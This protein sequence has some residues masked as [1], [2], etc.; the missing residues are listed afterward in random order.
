MKKTLLILVASLGFLALPVS[1]ETLT[2]AAASDLSY[3]IDELAAA[4]ALQVP[5]A[6]LKTS[7]GSSG[8]IYAQIRNGAPFDVFM[9]ADMKYP[10]QLAQDGAAERATLAPYAVG[11]I[12]LWSLDPRFDLSQGMRILNDARLNRIA[13]ANPDVAP[14]GR[15]ARA[16][17]MA[18]GFWGVV[19]DKLVLG[20][21]I[22]QTAQLVQSG[23][24]QIGIVSYPTVLAPKVRGSGSYYLIPED[25]VPPIEQGVIVTRHG[26]ANPLAPRFL[27][28]L[29]STAARAILLRHGFSL[30]REKNA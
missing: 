16:S 19:K 12:V 6:E 1:A 4:F 3:S 9:S 14:Y 13:I 15:A 7:L 29:Q 25:G 28:F 26:A 20:D 5:G 18:L 23:T 30:P 27:Q 10:A 2:V 11:R 21:N 22:A 17:L 8:S 24:A